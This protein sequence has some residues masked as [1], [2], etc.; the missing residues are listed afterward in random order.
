M[1]TALT[2]VLECATAS[3]LIQTLSA[4]V[5]SIRTDLGSA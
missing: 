4:R 2:A 1:E 3:L 5:D